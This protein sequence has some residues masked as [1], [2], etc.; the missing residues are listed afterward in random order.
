MKIFI[1]IATVLLLLSACASEQQATVTPV[2]TNPVMGRSA[3]VTMGK[4]NLDRSKPSTLS[5]I[6]AVEVVGGREG[7]PN[8][9]IQQQLQRIVQSYIV[10]K[11]YPVVPTNGDFQLQARI[12]LA[13]AVETEQ[14]LQERGGIDP[15]LVGADQEAGKGS[16][17]IELKQGRALRWR[18]AVQIYILPEY[19][20]VISTQRI[21]RAV[22]QLLQTWP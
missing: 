22:A 7:I 20:P 19:D 15:G 10:N 5:W 21:E 11:G 8:S 14:L 6:S 16:L 9:E 1:Y 3:I 4:P 2:K 13:N 17:V 12:V 18:G